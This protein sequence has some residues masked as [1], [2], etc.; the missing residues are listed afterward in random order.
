M[1]VEKRTEMLTEPEVKPV[2]TF[3]DGSINSNFSARLVD[4]TI[5]DERSV[6]HDP[7]C[8]HR[9]ARISGFSMNYL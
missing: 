5:T 6:S 1:L 7:T 9:R 8:L 4:V 3:E 2:Y